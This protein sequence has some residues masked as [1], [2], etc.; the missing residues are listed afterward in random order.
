MIRLQY[1]KGVILLLIVFYSGIGLCWI[2]SYVQ[3]MISEIHESWITLLR[4]WKEFSIC[5]FKTC[6]FISQQ[7]MQRPSLISF[8]LEFYLSWNFIFLGI[9]FEL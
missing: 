7:S 1:Y 2:R 9:S 3:V 5:R 6:R 8:G 4:Q